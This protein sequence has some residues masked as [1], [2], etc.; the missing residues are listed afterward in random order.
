VVNCAVDIDTQKLL[1][2][3]HPTPHF[4]SPQRA[5]FGAPRIIHIGYDMSRYLIGKEIFGS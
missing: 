3:L 5:A 1:P 2:L 4:S